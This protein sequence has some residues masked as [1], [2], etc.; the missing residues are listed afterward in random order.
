MDNLITDYYD[1][2]NPKAFSSCDDR[3]PGSGSCVDCFKNQYYGGHEISYDCEEKRKLYVLRYFPVH[4]KENYSGAERIPCDVIDEWFDNEHVD[5]LSVGGGPGSDIYGVLAYLKEEALRRQ[6]DLS[7]DVLRLDIED[8]WDGVFDDVMARFFPLVGYRNM[9]L[10]VSDGIDSISDESFDLVT[11]SYLTSELSTESCLNLAE[12]VDSVLVDGGVLMINDR[13]EDV[14][15][16]DI[17]SMFERIEVSY[18]KYSLSAWA[19]YSY[20]REISRVVVPKF[21][22]SS[23]IFVGVKE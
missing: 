10:D 4:G 13:P 7:V 19:G 18:K 17:R 1:D 5:I 8:Q 15:E 14:V 21:S 12:E 9:K 2:L 23:S 11:L 3:T 16:Q 20:P 6:V 22:M